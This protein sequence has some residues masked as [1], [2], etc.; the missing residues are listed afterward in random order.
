MVPPGTLYDYRSIRAGKPLS[1]IVDEVA[2]KGEIV[3]G[4]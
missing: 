2:G 4:M 1:R 3:E